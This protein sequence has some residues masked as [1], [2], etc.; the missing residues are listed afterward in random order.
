M[1]NL[2]LV[3]ISGTSTSFM[4]NKIKKAAEEMKFAPRF[5]HII[6]NDDLGRAIEQAE[7]LVRD[8]VRD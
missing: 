2:V 1:L 3:C 5:D 4:L 7:V 8:F 6:I